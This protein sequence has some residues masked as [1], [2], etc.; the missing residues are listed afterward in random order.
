MSRTSKLRRFAPVLFLLVAIASCSEQTPIEPQTPVALQPPVDAGL[1]LVREA[2]AFSLPTASKSVLITSAGGEVRLHGHVV[3]VPEGAV[4]VPT[5]FTI[6]V[7]LDKLVNVELTATVQT[8]LGG[9]VDVG[10]A[11]FDR[12]VVLG[13][14][15]TNADIRDFANPDDLY[16]AH[17]TDA[18]EQVNLPSSVDHANEMVYATLPHFSKYCMASN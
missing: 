14:R 8:L 4:S 15:Y 3:I 12:P 5:L 1:R 2:E 9:I 16:I 18:G 7:P 10:A 11:G 6:L 13:L 17:I